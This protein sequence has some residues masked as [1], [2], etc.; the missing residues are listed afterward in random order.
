MAPPENCGNKPCA[1]GLSFFP[2]KYT[3]IN[4]LGSIPIFWTNPN[5]IQLVVY[6]IIF[7]AL[8]QWYI[9]L[10]SPWPNSMG[11]SSYSWR[12]IHQVLQKMG[13]GISWSW[14]ILW[15]GCDAM[16]LD[17]I[18][19]HYHPMRRLYYICHH[20]SH[21]IDTNTRYIPVSISIYANLHTHIHTH[22]HIYI[23]NNITEV[24]PDF[25]GGAI[26]EFKV[27]RPRWEPQ[28]AWRK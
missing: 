27:Q 28:C 15:L 2:L 14:L 3:K 5:W 10:L 13:W 11:Y 8:F 20:N 12:D 1:D 19:S 6:P 23:Y 9:R 18:V 4:L 26:W 16:K 22:T 7:L 25:M 17:T 24:G 21:Y